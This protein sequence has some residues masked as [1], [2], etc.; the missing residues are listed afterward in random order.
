MKKKSVYLL[1]PS[2]IQTFQTVTAP[3]EVEPNFEAD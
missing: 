2:F 1:S 3:A